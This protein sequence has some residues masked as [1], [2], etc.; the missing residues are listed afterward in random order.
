MTSVNYDDAGLMPAQTADWT[1]SACSLAW[2]NRALHIAYADTEW[3]AVDYIGN[4]T[5]I[6]PSYGLMDGSGR[7][8][9]ECLTEQGAPSFVCWPS[10]DS[11]MVMA[12]KYGLLLGGVQWCHWVVGR[13]TDGTLLY[14]ANSA[15]GWQGVTDSMGKGDWDRL[16]PFAAVVTPL[17][18]TMPGGEFVFKSTA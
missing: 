18:Y 4:P 9:A 14:L 10:W 13:Y 1:C 12:S 15:E 16:G 7:R 3:G 5:N 17:N 8:L 6:N 11:A 2:M